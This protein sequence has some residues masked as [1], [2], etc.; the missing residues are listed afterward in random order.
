ML[1]APENWER[2][3]TWLE[4]VKAP[5]VMGADLMKGAAHFCYF[6]PGP[7]IGG[8]VVET[9]ILRRSPD[10]PPEPDYVIDFAAGVAQ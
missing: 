2:T 10:Q 4:S 5:L 7:S 6:E 8:Y 1:T 9:V 3:V